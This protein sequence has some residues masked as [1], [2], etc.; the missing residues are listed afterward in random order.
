MYIEN[1]MRKWKLKTISDAKIKNE[2]R[3]EARKKRWN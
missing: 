3:I 2:I 1:R